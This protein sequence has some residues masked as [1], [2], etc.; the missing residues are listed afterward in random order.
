[1]KMYVRNVCYCSSHVLDSY[2]QSAS[3]LSETDRTFTEKAK[4]CFA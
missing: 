3:F 4:M 1:M 2:D